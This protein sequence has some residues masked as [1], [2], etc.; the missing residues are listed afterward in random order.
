MSSTNLGGIEGFQ[1]VESVFEISSPRV[2]ATYLFLLTIFSVQMTTGRTGYIFAIIGYILLFSIVFANGKEKLSGDRTVMVEVVVMSTILVITTIAAVTKAGLL[3]IILFPPVIIFNLFFV[4]RAISRRIFY[5]CLSRL[6]AVVTLIGLPAIITGSFGPIPSYDVVSAP[7]GLPVELHALTSFFMNPN[8]MGA[9]AVFGTLA[10]I[11]ESFSSRS[12]ISKVLFAINLSGVYLSQSRAAALALLTGLT[13]IAIYYLTDQGTVAVMSLLGV[14]SAASFVLVKFS[15][16]PGPDIIQNIGLNNRVELWTAAG[17][18]FIDRPLTGWGIGNVPEAMT[19]YIT[20][21]YLK[22]TGPHSSYIRMFAAT[23]LIGGVSYILI[24][25]K[26]ALNR[27]W[28]IT[29]HADATE[30]GMVIGA[31]VLH[32]FGGNTIFGLAAVS[33]IPAI[34]LGYAQ[35]SR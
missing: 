26:C 21:S 35:S 14:L 4:P 33:V 6:T 22:T 3:R 12:T 19:P 18:A 23:G 30:Y 9:V 17:Q 15:V 27:L 10:A 29:H 5:G 34:V 16:I 25:M 1:S 32:T 20:S 31:F 8:L 7:P 2:T 11:W 13:I 28:T 24:C